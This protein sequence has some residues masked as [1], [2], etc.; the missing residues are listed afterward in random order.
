VSVMMLAL[1]PVDLLAG[2]VPARSAALGGFDRFAIDHPA[3]GLASRPAC[4]RA[5]WTKTKLIGSH[6]HRFATHRS[7]A[8]PSSGLE[9][10]AAIDAKAGRSGDVKQ[11]LGNSP[12]IQ[13]AGPPPPIY[14]RHKRLDNCPF[15]VRHV[16]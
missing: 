1:A 13:F 9:N 7:N 15:R 16:V 8:A 3:R 4:S 12:K 10:H 5:C 6:S 11:A 2:I 14:C